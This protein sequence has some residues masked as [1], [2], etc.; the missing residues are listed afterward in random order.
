[1]NE[2][3]RIRPISDADAS[4]AMSEHTLSNLAARIT[5]TPADTPTR[6]TP[7]DRRSIH[8]RRRL[9][10]LA[11]VVAAGVLLASALGKTGNRVGPVN[12]GPGKAQAALTFK[13][14]GRY[15]VVL[16][17]NPLADPARYR[18]ELA[19][20]HLKITLT[21]VPVSPSLVGTVVSSDEPPDE[22]AGDQIIPVTAVGRCQ[23][24][25]GAGCQV[26]V[27]IPIAF[28]GSAGI[29][30]GRAARPG[31]QYVS[32]APASAPGEAMHGLKFENDPVSAVLAMLKARHITVPQY[33]YEPGYKPAH[34]GNGL[35]P[36][37]VPGNWVVKD[38]VPW[39]AG[40]VLLFVAPASTTP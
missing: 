20:H 2:I 16:V 34:P 32:S 9:T 24:P 31:E 23:N 38:A 30:F 28:H 4:D 22:P 36:N 19:A 15:I 26:G 35:P 7:R 13:K 5:S 27:Q 14:E 12:L 33:R 6:R 10:A 17:K 25:G 29:V 40:Q 39:A 3:S 21:L 11:A 37:P 1:M 18:A 8:R